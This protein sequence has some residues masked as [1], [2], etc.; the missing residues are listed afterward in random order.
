MPAPDWLER[1][2]GVAAA[3]AVLS[4]GVVSVVVLA[5]AV[6]NWVRNEKLSANC[7]LTY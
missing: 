5:G 6:K 4:E 7:S 3:V 1:L 2:A